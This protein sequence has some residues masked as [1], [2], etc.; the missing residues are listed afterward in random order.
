MPAR[1]LYLGF[2]GFIYDSLT[3]VVDTF[4][5]SLQILGASQKNL[6]SGDYGFFEI[7]LFGNL[8][9]PEYHGYPFIKMYKFEYQNDVNDIKELMKRIQQ[10]YVNQIYISCYTW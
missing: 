3:N 2:I 6:S 1:R 4:I 5:D 9:P 10:Q 8:L 7:D